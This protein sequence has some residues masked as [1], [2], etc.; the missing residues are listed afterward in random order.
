[1]QQSEPL[2]VLGF[3]ATSYDLSAIER[4]ILEAAL[5]R[6]LEG[7]PATIQVC[8]GLCGRR[9]LQRAGP[10]A[11]RMGWQGSPHAFVL[12]QEGWNL[13]KAE[14]RRPLRRAG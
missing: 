6:P 13:L 9:L 7:E 3:M 4:A 12:T 1:M 14:R 8:L 5:R 11:A 10:L 2:G